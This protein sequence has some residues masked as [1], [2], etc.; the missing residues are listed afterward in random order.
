MSSVY[1][2]DAATARLLI[3]HLQGLSDPPRRKLDHD[4]LIELMERMGFVQIDSINTVER[5]HHM[6]MFSRNTTYRQKLL[7]QAV[8]KR[9]S[10]FENWTHDASI[11]PSKFFPFWQ[12][13]FRREKT[14]LGN[15]YRNWHGDQCLSEAEKVLDHIRENGPVLSRDFASDRKGK[16]GGWWDWHPSK[17]AL[18]FLWRTGDLAVT[19]RQG[20]Q[21]V[22]DLTER[23]LSDHADLDHHHDEALID[24]AC[25]SAL[26]RLGYGSAADIAGFWASISTAEANDWLQR[27]PS[28]TVIPV[29]VE[30]VDGSPTRQLY[31]RG[32]LESVCATLPDPINRLRVLSPFDPLIRDRKRLM[33]IFGFDYRI[34]VFVPAAKRKYGYYVFP[35]L[36]GDRM[37]GRIDMKADRPSGTLNI[38]NLWLEPGVKAT[39]GRMS[40][41]ESELDRLRRFANLEKIDGLNGGS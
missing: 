20:F 40:A 8:E 37:V 27:Q 41:L 4:G 3:L 22:Y 13:R 14:R 7:A 9:R 34:E 1:T 25:R 24:W 33:K 19:G 10:A 26:E 2:L 30:S 12:A 38:T 11:I 39:K 31:A 21:K 15:M 5:A 17:T 32:D 35:L 23:V 36:E 28:E 16:S 29:R 18:E 6:I